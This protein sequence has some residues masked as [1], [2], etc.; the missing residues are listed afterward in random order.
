MFPGSVE[1]ESRKVNFK[2]DVC[3]NSAFS[4]HHNA[5]RERAKSTDDLLTSQSITGRR[6]FTDCEMLDAII[7]SALKKLLTSV[8]FRKRVR[9]EEQR[10]QKDDRFLQGRQIAHMIC[11]HFRGAVQGLLDLFNI[12]LQN[13]DVQDFDTRWDQALFTAS[14]LPTE[15]VLEGLCKSKLQDSVQLQTVSD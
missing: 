12:R 10:A 7:A 6:D 15:S 8:H 5:E 1:F 14:E 9:V 2:T 4:S 11:E 3:A 13:D